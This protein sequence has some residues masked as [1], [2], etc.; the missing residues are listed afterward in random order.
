MK[1]RATD[2]CSAPSKFSITSRTLDD[3]CWEW[4]VGQLSHPERMRKL[5]DEYMEHSGSEREAESSQL[6]A[7]RAAIEAAKKEEGSYLDS[8]GRAAEEY[9]DTLVARAQE[10]RNRYV[11]LEK[12]L[13]D[14][15]SM[16]ENREQQAAIMASF[17]DSSAEALKRLE[18]ATFEE[19]RLAL[20]VYD[21]QATLTKVAINRAM[22]LLGWA[23]SIQTPTPPKRTLAPRIV[24]IPSYTDWHRSLPSPAIPR[25][26]PAR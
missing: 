22:R 21:V 9:R 24:L 11:A 13:A 12:D 18:N 10:A 15:E 3:A 20:R 1:W 23:G 26:S 16:A 8:L 19:K 17:A 25:A 6:Q 2:T 5:H 7:T 4:F 14:R